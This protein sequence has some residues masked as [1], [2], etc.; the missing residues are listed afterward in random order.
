MRHLRNLV[1]SATAFICVASCLSAA[2]IAVVEG[3]YTAAERPSEASG[4]PR[5][6]DNVLSAMRAVGLE[7]DHIKDSDIE[8]KGLDAYKLV[9][10]THNG[11]MT[12]E[13]QDVIVAWLRA[14]GKA[15]CIGSAGP[16]VMA[17]LG[18]RATGGFKTQ[19]PGQFDFV[20]FEAGVLPGAPERMRQDSW[21]ISVWELTGEGKTAAWWTD[22][23]GKRTEWPAVLV[24]DKGLVMGHIL[25]GADAINA[26]TFLL[27]A[28]Q[29]FQPREGQAAA[30][31]VIEAAAK[32]GER[33]PRLS[34]L[35]TRA[36]WV[37]NP[38]PTQNQVVAALNHTEALLTRAR[39]MMASRKS[40]EAVALAREA[41]RQH[42]EALCALAPSRE[43]EIR[44][45]WIHPSRVWDR[46]D[47]A[48]RACADAGL[49][50]LIPVV[51]GGYY[52]YYDSDV[53]PRVQGFEDRPDQLA[54]CLKAARKYGLQVHPWRVNWNASRIRDEEFE[55]LRAAGRLQQDYEGETERW[56]CPSNEKNQELELAAMVE[57]AAKY[58]VDGIHF[59]YIRYPNE[60]HCYCDTCRATFE[61][62]RGA[63]AHAWPMSAYGGD[64]KQE[65]RAF[66]CSRI[67]KLV[68][69]VSREARTVRPDIVISAAVFRGWPRPYTTVGQ[70]WKLWVE[71]GYLDFISPMNYTNDLELF[72]E[73][74]I[75]D[76][77]AVANRIPLAMGIGATSS[78]S[79]MQW[80]AE[81]V[82]QALASHEL[83]CDGFTI[84]CYGDAL[85]DAIFPGMRTG[86]TRDNTYPGVR[87]PT[88]TISVPP[89][90]SLPD[91]Q[92]AYR[93][94]APLQSRI[95][96]S[97]TLP[98]GRTAERVLGRVQLESAHGDVLEELDTFGTGDETTLD[99][100]V[101]PE[102]GRYRL[103]VLGWARV[104]RGDWIRFA[105]RGPVMTV[106]TRGELR[107]ATAPERPPK[108]SGSGVKVG[109]FRHGYGASGILAAARAK[110][111]YTAEY[112]T[113]LRPAWLA[114]CD[115]V[116]V[117]QP[118]GATPPSEADHSALQAYV[119]K[120]R[121]V[122]LTHDA[123]G[124][125]SFPVLFPDVCAGG[126][127]HPKETQFS[128]ELPDGTTRQGTHTYYDRIT[129]R[130][131]PAARV[132]ARAPGG[133]DASPLAV[134]GP[135]G[136][137]RVACTGLALGLAPD[138]TDAALSAGETR[139]LDLMLDALRGK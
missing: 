87:G 42:A 40:A 93:E 133:S 95:C 39:L 13:E 114:A 130:P 49:N 47:A 105:R 62:W 101:R 90:T 17:E 72:V 6:A 127:G 23:E 83:G 119:R 20:H 52:A 111:A 34:A 15:L 9:I 8:A 63:E 33:F 122:L 2:D 103:A 132:V 80:P 58:P 81:L 126:S 131:G 113:S 57:M 104:A 135:V 37:R 123:V 121:A 69:A 99:V 44:A 16:R 94:R 96:I 70:N 25:T 24:S 29:H 35:A 21:N 61:Q 137:G 60:S 51:A 92:H 107:R 14:G 125:R 112:L 68:A 116:I 138:N 106:L 88:V 36:R 1:V 46:W 78:S 28:V 77:A 53:V 71:N 11:T 108:F 91:V 134:A 55:Q 27:A 32:V 109:V 79:Q 50:A 10:F 110:P 66:R 3:E 22:S 7:A 67:T 124:Y 65:Y 18:F 129:L 74:T 43:G 136:R 5:W 118:R 98:G 64:L 102:R 73:R 4:V 45:I 59:D 115:L 97:T 82:E 19:Y 56:L 85:S 84:F 89:G 139:L 76:A 41:E 38:S 117:P 75:S 128:I 54:E 31:R 86:L 12:D 100:S 30:G 48:C 26:P 120:G